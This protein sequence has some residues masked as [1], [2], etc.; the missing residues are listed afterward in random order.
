MKSDLCS[1]M[2]VGHKPTQAFLSSVYRHQPLSL[3]GLN[4]MYYKGALLSVSSSSCSLIKL[5]CPFAFLKSVVDTW[6]FVFLLLQTL[7]NWI[8][9]ALGTQ[10]SML[11]TQIF[12]F[13]FALR[14][15][16]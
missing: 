12:S 1:L 5:P 14:K 4:V 6:M 8:T 10:E 16:E 7:S 11:K 2:N 15:D 3:M 13:P 9:Q